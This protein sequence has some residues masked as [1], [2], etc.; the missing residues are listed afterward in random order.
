MKTPVLKFFKFLEDREDREIPLAFKIIYIPEEIKDEDLHIKG[1]FS[2]SNTRVTSLPKNMYVKG[3][4]YLNST[5]LLENLPDNLQV[6]GDLFATHS[7]ISHIPD[8]LR[9]GG[10]LVLPGSGLSLRFHP[11]QIKKMI[12]EKGGYVK[13]GIFL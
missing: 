11:T 12:E 1:S 6:W 10:D 8:R 3:D 7:S 13:G 9:I 4:L 5:Y 2:L